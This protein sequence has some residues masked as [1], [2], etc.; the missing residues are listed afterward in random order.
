MPMPACAADAASVESDDLD[1]ITS[2]K[3]NHSSYH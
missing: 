2:V 3:S 1:H